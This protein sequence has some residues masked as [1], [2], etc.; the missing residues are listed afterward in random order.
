MV[1]HIEGDVAWA[2]EQNEIN[3]SSPKSQQRRK[4]KTD[5][6]KK[7]STNRSMESLSLAQNNRRFTL[8]DVSRIATILCVFLIS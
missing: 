5:Q 7:K 3:H 1:E 6:K 2:N 4:S 8:K